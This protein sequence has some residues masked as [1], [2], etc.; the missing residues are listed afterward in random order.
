MW[1]GRGKHP[2]RQGWRGGRDAKTGRATGSPPADGGSCLPKHPPPVPPRCT[3]NFFASGGGSAEAVA[4]L[5]CGER[6]GG[7]VLGLAGVGWG[8]GAVP[9][10]RELAGSDA[11][12]RGGEHPLPRGSWGGS[13]L[14]PSVSWEREACV[15]QPR[16]SVLGLAL[17]VWAVIPPLLCA[18][19]RAGGGA[20]QTRVI[21]LIGKSRDGRKPA[22]SRLPY[23]PW[24]MPANSPRCVSRRLLQP[25][26]EP[27]QRQVFH[28]CPGEAVARL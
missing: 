14:V 18:A 11:A 7:S 5:G 22:R 27:F 16:C 10:L 19:V 25:G 24:L 15:P 2:G 9:E 13:A 17:P 3:G 20:G 28:H 12:G 6:H 21:E 26:F 1:G 23:P 8:Q 4:D